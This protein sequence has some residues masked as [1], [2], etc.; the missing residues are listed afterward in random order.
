MFDEKRLGLYLLN[1]ILGGPGMNSRLNLSLREKHGYVYNVESSLT[2]YTDT[3][4]FSIYFGC[5]HKYADKC[6][7]LI[8]KELKN[9]C[10]HKLTTSQLDA[11]KKQLIGQLGVS[12][13]NRESI[14]L[15]MGKSFLHLNKY[16]SL[17]ETCR[18]IESLTADNLFQIANEI[19]EPTQMLTLKYE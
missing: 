10:D 4:I 12:S 1:N 17:H 9:L 11:A 18:R 19:F 14:S 7:S 13:D 16:N 6:Q 3:G 15:S 5:D 8:F 2:S